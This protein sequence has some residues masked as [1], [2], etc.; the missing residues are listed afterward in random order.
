M[1]GWE[2]FGLTE[3]N[4]LYRF[5]I[6]QIYNFTILEQLNKNIKLKVLDFSAEI[7]AELCYAELLCFRGML[8]IFQDESLMALIKAG[9]KIRRSFNTYK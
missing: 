2:N 4:F 3:Y 1:I 6:F 7:H 9:W 5:L 8:V